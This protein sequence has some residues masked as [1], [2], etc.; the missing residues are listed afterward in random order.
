MTLIASSLRETDAEARLFG[1]EEATAPSAGVLEQAGDGTLFINEIEDLPPIAQR[2]LIGVLE[3][4]TLHAPRRQ[5]ADA[6]FDARVLSSAQPGIE[7][8]RRHVG[9]SSGAICSRI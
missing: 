5:R 9:W 6:R 4:G 7:K 3:S 8:S 2:L 1:R